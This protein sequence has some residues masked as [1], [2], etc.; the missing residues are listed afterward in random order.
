M[1]PPANTDGLSLLPTLLGKSDEQ[2][3]HEYLYWEY[4]GKQAV[5]LGDWKALRHGVGEPIELYDLANDIGEQHD[6]ASDHPEVITRIED[7]MQ[8]G[9]TPSELFPLARVSGE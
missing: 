4:H 3:S 2:Q 7:I 1:Q 9:R 8:N 5:R 6:V